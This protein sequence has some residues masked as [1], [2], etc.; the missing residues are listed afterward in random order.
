MINHQIISCVW[1]FNKVV[2]TWSI[3]ARHAFFCQKRIAKPCPAFFL[4]QICTTLCMKQPNIVQIAHACRRS[5]NCYKEIIT[6]AKQ[7]WSFVYWCLIAIP[8]IHRAHNT[9]RLACKLPWL[10]RINCCD[11]NISCSCLKM[12]IICTIVYLTIRPHHIIPSIITKPC[13]IK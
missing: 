11:I 4:Q 3:L 7:I 8:T 9:V 10:F 1:I 2:V 5:R 12:F 13:H 6:A